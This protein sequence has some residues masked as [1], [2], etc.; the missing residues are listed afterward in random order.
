MVLM[1][2]I[3]T[4]KVKITLK[5]GSRSGPKVLITDRD[6][7]RRDLQRVETIVETCIC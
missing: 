3:H 1:T 6:P 4:K 2:F 7:T 5:P